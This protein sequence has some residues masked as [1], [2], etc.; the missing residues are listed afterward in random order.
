[1]R[2]LAFNSRASFQQDIKI[3]RPSGVCL[4]LCV[5]HALTHTNAHTHLKT[6][7]LGAVHNRAEH[8]ALQVG[9]D[10]SVFV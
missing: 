3:S 10:Q 6:R 1:M 7:R 2:P 4:F 5:P 8:V 9:S